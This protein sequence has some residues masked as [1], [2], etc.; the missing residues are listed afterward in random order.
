VN[1]TKEKKRRTFQMLSYTLCLQLLLWL[2]WSLP[3]AE[4]L[5]SISVPISLSL[6]YW[7]GLT[8]KKDSAEE[9]RSVVGGGSASLFKG[10]SNVGHISQE[11]K[12]GSECE[13]GRGLGSSSYEDDGAITQI[14]SA[15]FFFRGSSSKGRQNKKVRGE[16][17]VEQ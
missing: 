8:E 17:Q 12:K 14:D 7:Q 4:Y 16:F 6:F 3:L 2:Q 1:D 13:R 10:I 9:V 15:R 11:C 5:F